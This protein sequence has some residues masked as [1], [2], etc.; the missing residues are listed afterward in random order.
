MGKSSIFREQAKACNWDRVMEVTVER[1]VARGRRDKV[2]ETLEGCLDFISIM[3]GCHWRV[4]NRGV[5]CSDLCY[6]R[7]TLA[8]CRGL[9][10]TGVGTGDQ[11]GGWA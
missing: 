2:T 10:G 11:L 3:T 8:L 4:F 7:L 1:R 6:Q 9:G 5:M